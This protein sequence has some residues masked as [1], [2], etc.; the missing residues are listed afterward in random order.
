MT[1]FQQCNPHAASAASPQPAALTPR[2]P[3]EAGRGATGRAQSPSTGQGFR[4]PPF[5]AS[6]SLQDS[7]L[8][9]GSYPPSVALSQKSPFSFAS[10]IPATSFSPLSKS[11][12]CACTPLLARQTQHETAPSQAHSY[13]SVR[14]EEAQ[15]TAHLIYK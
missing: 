14:S 13:P 4:T 15:F 12:K 8:R 7:T 5:H 10:K 1:P 9:G 2:T 11:S 6:F 3:R